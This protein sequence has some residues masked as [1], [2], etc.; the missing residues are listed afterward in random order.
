MVGY[1]NVE[2][3][4][5]EE[6]ENEYVVEVKHIEHGFRSVST[7]TIHIPMRQGPSVTSTRYITWR[8]A[9]KHYLS[10]EDRVD[11]RGPRKG[12]LEDKTLRMAHEIMSY[13]WRRN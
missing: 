8:F 13:Y 11:K 9:A 12:N 4:I 5:N 3:T 6:C 7:N 10:E 1:S 2:L